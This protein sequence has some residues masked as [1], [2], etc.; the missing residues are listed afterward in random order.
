MAAHRWLVARHT[1]HS[2]SSQVLLNYRLAAVLSTSHIGSTETPAK[3]Q[4]ASM[5]HSMIDTAWARRN[6]ATVSSWAV[7]GWLLLKVRR[8]AQHEATG[9]TGCQRALPLRY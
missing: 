8:E 3:K 9:C 1:V 6:R 4:L 2:P 7:P 5:L